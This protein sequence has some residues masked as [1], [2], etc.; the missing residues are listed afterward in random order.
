MPEIFFRPCDQQRILYEITK[1]SDWFL[2]ISHKG[3]GGQLESRL[4]NTNKYVCESVTPFFAH[5]LPKLDKLLIN[6]YKF[7]LNSNPDKFSWLYLFSRD[8]V[9]LTF[10]MHLLME[11]CF[12]FH[13]YQFF[14]LGKSFAF[15]WSIFSSIWPQWPFSCTQAQATRIESHIIIISQNPFCF[16]QTRNCCQT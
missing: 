6:M 8:T 16:R 15:I 3:F 1:Y 4:R 10:T 7:Y 5:G 14:L 13:S 9:H 11:A 2:V 12:S